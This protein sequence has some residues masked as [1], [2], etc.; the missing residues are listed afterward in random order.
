MKRIIFIALV[1]SALLSSDMFAATGQVQPRDTVM[2]EVRGTDIDARFVPAVVQTQPG[3][4][5]QFVVSEGLHTVSAYHPDNR[6]PLRIPNTA[7]SFDS[8]LLKAGDTWF[9][10]I[11]VEGVYDYFCLPHE[12]M[13]HV[14]RILSGSVQS[15]PNYPKGKIPEAALKKLNT[16]TTTF[17]TKRH[18]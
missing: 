12:R 10:T 13:G 11:E 9:L 17:L 3:D 4:V 2:V 14:G 5:I 8:G 15:I 1:A 18:N 6:R 7:A 16:E